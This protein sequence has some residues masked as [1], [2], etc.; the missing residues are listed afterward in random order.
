MILFLNYTF[1]CLFDKIK[2]E[3]LNL[4]Y[5][6]DP[7]NTKAYFHWGPYYNISILQY[8][9]H[10]D[11]SSIVIGYSQIILIRQVLNSSSTATLGMI[12]NSVGM[13]MLKIIAF[14]EISNA[15]CCAILLYCNIFWK[16]IFHNNYFIRK[17]AF[18]YA[19]PD[20]FDWTCR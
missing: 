19:E 16:N 11:D 4:F 3:K 5:Q 9:L 12:N 18:I 13:T 2:V 8:F 17:L 14:R 15:I 1:V 20:D 10:T 7:R 6:D